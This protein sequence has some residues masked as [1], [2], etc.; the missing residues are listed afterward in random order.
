MDTQEKV[1]VVKQISAAT[2]RAELVRL[3]ARKAKLSNAIRALET[4]AKISITQR[5]NGRARVLH[6]VPR[7]VDIGTAA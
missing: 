5:K 1:K 2:I 3:R 6:A 7:R 4:Y